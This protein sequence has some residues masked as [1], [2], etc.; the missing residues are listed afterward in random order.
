MLRNSWSLSLVQRISVA[1]VFFEGP[2]WLSSHFRKARIRTRYDVFL[3][4]FACAL[5]VTAELYSFR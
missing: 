1:R 5:L 3:L 4:S 2:L